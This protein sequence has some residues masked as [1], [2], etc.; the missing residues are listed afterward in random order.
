[1][2]NNPAMTKRGRFNANITP[3]SHVGCIVSAQAKRNKERDFKKQR[4]ITYKSQAKGMFHVQKDE[5]CAD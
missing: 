1:M 5:P 3:C 2:A 4:T